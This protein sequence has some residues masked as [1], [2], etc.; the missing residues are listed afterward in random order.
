MLPPPLLTNQE[1]NMLDALA[2]MRLLDEKESNKMMWFLPLQGRAWA[3]ARAICGYT[4][5]PLD[6]FSRA[7]A[8]TKMVKAYTTMYELGRQNEAK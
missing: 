4:R 1:H 7:V 5:F 8:K 6:S 3:C 2:I